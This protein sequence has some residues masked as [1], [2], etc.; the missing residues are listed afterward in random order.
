M[1]LKFYWCDTCDCAAIKCPKLGC[2]SS[3]CNSVTCG[4][5]DKNVFPFWQEQDLSET[6]V[7]EGRWLETSS[8]KIVTSEF[9][10][11]LELPWSNGNELKPNPSLE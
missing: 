9:G 6:E 10:S 5:C 11:Q 2:N 4:W 1:L 7:K 8:G 3:M